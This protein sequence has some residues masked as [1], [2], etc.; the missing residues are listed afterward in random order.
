VCGQV[1]LGLSNSSRMSGTG[2]LSS[3][4]TQPDQAAMQ[5]PCSSH[6]ASYPACSHTCIEVPHPAPHP[7]LQPDLG[8]EDGD[9]AAGVLAGAGLEVGKNHA[10]LTARQRPRI[11]LRQWQGSSS[12]LGSI[13]WNLT[14]VARLQPC[15]AGRRAGG[16]L[17]SGYSERPAQGAART[18]LVPC[19][20]TRS[21]AMPRSSWLRA[22]TSCKSNQLRAGSQ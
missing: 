4:P 21:P 20:H 10:A 18:R 15:L 1:W 17:L 12:E 2:R 22:I 7:R 19:R 16:L 3:R 5:Q 13:L 14:V 6:A 11:H 9:V 8:P